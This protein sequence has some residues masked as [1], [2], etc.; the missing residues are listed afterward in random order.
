[1]TCIVGVASKGRVHIGGDSCGISG[2]DKVIRKDKKV[3]YNGEFVFGFSSSFRMGQI[4]QYDFDPPEVEYDDLMV[5]MVKTFIPSLRAVFKEGAYTS[6]ESSQEHGG[7]FLVGGRGRLFNI[8]RDFQV[9]ENLCGYMA[10]GCGEAYALGSL[11]TTDMDK[12][13]KPEWRIEQAL[14][15]AANFSGGVSEPF[16]FVNI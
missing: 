13:L 16:N 1:M 9:G 8:Q 2:L 15:A 7:S 11:H 10:I 12:T 3:F 5:Y 6:I 4:L 14:S